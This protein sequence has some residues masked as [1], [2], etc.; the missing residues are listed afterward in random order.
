M[1]IS[2]G[3]CCHWCQWFDY[4]DVKGLMSSDWVINWCQVI[5]WCKWIDLWLM[6]NVYVLSLMRMIDVKWKPIDEDGF[7]DILC[8][9]WWLIIVL[10]WLI[11][12]TKGWTAKWSPYGE[13]PHG[14]MLCG[15]V[16][17]ERT[18][19]CMWNNGMKIN[20]VIGETILDG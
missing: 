7:F 4:F 11:R 8:I 18:Y 1:V 17:V 13:I 20:E 15:W 6:N 5:D 16:V 12:S 19:A 9:V 2:V 10:S 3:S 14:K